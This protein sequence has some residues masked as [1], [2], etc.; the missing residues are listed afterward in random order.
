MEQRRKGWVSEGE[1]GGME[2]GREGGGQ[3]SEFVGE[4]KERTS[5][6]ST[7]Q[8]GVKSVSYS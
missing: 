1:K 6:V 5:N 8:N 3:V 4:R 2:G 7:V